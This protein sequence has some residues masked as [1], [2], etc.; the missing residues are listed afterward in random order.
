ML[1]SPFGAIEDWNCHGGPEMDVSPVNCGLR[2]PFGAIEDW[3]RTRRNF[4]GARDLLRL[5]FG[6]IEDWNIY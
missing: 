1:R 5:P 3:N 2:S 4:E 6:A